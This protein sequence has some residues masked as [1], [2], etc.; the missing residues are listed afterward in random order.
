[1]GIHLLLPALIA[2]HVLYPPFML[3][4]MGKEGKQLPQTSLGPGVLIFLGNRATRCISQSLWT[5][6]RLAGSWVSS[7]FAP[8]PINLL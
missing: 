1:M 6:G 8:D 4:P 7:A 3:S 5:L 2:I